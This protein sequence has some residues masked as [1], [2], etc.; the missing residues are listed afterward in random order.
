MCH[1]CFVGKEGF[2]PVISV[3]VELFEYGGECGKMKQIGLEV[4]FRTLGLSLLFLDEVFQLSAKVIQFDHFDTPI[5]G[6]PFT[7]KGETC[8]DL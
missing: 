4:P 2:S 8:K 5:L 1:K 6:V 3:R 7:S